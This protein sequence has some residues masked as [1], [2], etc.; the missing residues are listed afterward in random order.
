M[1]RLC[2]AL[3]AVAAVLATTTVSADAL[4]TR[5]TRAVPFGQGSQEADAEVI[6]APILPINANVPVCVASECDD[7]TAKQDNSASASA[8]NHSN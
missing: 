1:K 4:S 8:S 2:I 6:S 5:S 3:G 7:A